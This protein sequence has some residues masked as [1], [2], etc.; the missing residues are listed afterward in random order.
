MGFWATGVGA[1]LVG[2]LARA[3]AADDPGAFLIGGR[4][5][6]PAGYPNANCALV[7][8]AFWIAAFLAGRR[9][10]PWPLRG[11]MLAVAGSTLQIAILAQSRASLIAVPVT[12]LLAL[13]LTPGR[14]RLLLSFTAAGLAALA[15]RG[16]LLDVYPTR[17][18]PDQ[19]HDALGGALTAVGV[20]AAA[21]AGVGMA[22]AF[23]DRRVELSERARRRV[24][25]AVVASCAALAIAGAVAVV[26]AYGNPVDRVQRAWSDFTEV[27]GDDGYLDQ[28]SSRFSGGVGSNRWDFWR[29]AVDQFKTAPLLGAGADNFALDYL[30]DRRSSEDPRY[31]H[32]LEMRT[33][34]GLGIVGALLFAGFLIAALA[35]AYGARRSPPFATAVAAT[36]LV[37]FAYW[38]IHGTV[39][40]LWE[41]PGLAGPA[42]AWLGLAVGLAR[43][44]PAVDPGPSSTVD[45]RS[46]PVTRLGLSAAVCAIALGVAASYLLPWLSARDVDAAA[47]SW[48]SD[49]AGAFAQLDRAARLNPLNDR[50]DLVS[51][52]IALRLGDWERARTAFERALDRTPR[53]WYALLQAAVAESQEGNFAE[54]SRLLHE[55][56]RLNPRE[57]TIAFA[58]AQVATRRPIPPETLV[59]MSLDR[60]ELITS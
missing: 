49:A 28:G 56:R 21:L 15:A 58:L 34:G 25:I 31:A 53:N 35:A 55:A 20:S 10:T 60:V 47:S 37:A 42:F 36:G 27:H 52:T 22:I 5:A 38:A 30:A 8:G 13:A 17:F 43:V 11:L 59:R 1:V 45:R 9:E 29:V 51:G 3:A 12:A 26:A 6:E 7:M 46:G 54:A 57:P 16:T 48:R 18:D 32:S 14:L 24:G 33:L 4:L 23:V 19:L 40:W 50:A 41:F 39:D 44:P 2:Y